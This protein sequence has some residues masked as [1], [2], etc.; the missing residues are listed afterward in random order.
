[1]VQLLYLQ[2]TSMRLP[3]PLHLPGTSSESAKCRMHETCA[4]VADRSGEEEAIGVSV[5]GTGRPPGLSSSWSMVRGRSFSTWMI[6]SSFVLFA[7]ES[8]SRNA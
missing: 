5:R 8:C 1:M 7:S 6:V 4:A 2:S 3:A